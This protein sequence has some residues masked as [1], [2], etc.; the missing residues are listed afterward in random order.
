MYKEKNIYGLYSE[1]RRIFLEA[2]NDAKARVFNYRH[3]LKGPLGEDLF[4]DVAIIGSPQAQSHVVVMSGTHGV[5]G[6]YGSIAQTAWMRD[7][8]ENKGPEDV[9]IVFI[10]LINPWG[11]AWIRRTNEENIDLNRNFIDFGVAGSDDEKYEYIHKSYSC[12][13]N[14]EKSKSSLECEVLDY[15]AELGW[16]KYISIVQTGQY[17]FPD[18]LYFGGNSPTWSNITLRKIVN[19]HLYGSRRVAFFDLHTGAGDYGH[20]MLMS[21]TEK[22]NKSIGDAKKIYGS[23]LYEILT[24][25][26]MISDTGVSA[27]AKGY[28]SQA[29]IEMLPT[30][31]CIP[32]VIE[33][34]TYDSRFVHSALKEDNCLHNHGDP[35]SEKGYEVKKM[36]MEAFNP[37]DTDWEELVIFRTLQILRRAR[38]VVS[39]N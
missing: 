21:I 16:D 4:T 6:Y 34:G 15:L 19:E 29:I 18:G 14:I 25:P 20:P 24:S 2:A 7:L 33:C 27:S 22:N 39:D 38:L 1:Y 13:K 32:L 36:V 26:D 23:W 37:S 3:S 9:A 30:A 12:S 28:T 31:K 35:L 17:S 5:E 11:T 8:K 10:H